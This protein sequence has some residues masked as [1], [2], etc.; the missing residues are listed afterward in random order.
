MSLPSGI[1]IGTSGWNYD[2]WKGNFYPDDISQDAMLSAN[3][4]HFGTVEVNGTF[5]SLPKP[6]IVSTWAQA[7]P[8]DFVF[9]VKASQYITHMKKLKNPEDALANLYEILRPLGD[10]LGPVL[11]QLPPSWQVDTK[12]LEKFLKT[13]SRDFRYTFEFR[14]TSWH[15]EEVYELLSRH[16]AALCFYDYEEQQS[17]RRHT[18][19]FIYMRLHGPEEQAYKGSYKDE[20]LDRYAQDCLNSRKSGKSVFCYFDNDEKA[21]APHDA[22]RLIKKIKDIE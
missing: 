4:E 10:R 9:S 5:Y 6:E 11:F 3:A 1:H 19:D 17:P 21:C 13:L 16:E 14:D 22:E 20:V 12:R 15:C 8:P 2:D 18:T 7:V